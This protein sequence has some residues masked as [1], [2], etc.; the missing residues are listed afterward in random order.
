VPAVLIA[1]VMILVTIS[2]GVLSG[3]DVFRTTPMAAL[4]EA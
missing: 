4:R 2:I 3:R 1:A